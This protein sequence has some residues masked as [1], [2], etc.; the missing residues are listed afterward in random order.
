MIDL[1]KIED[2]LFK[3]A[4]EYSKQSR[5]YLSNRHSFHSGSL[6]EKEKKMYE[7]KLGEKI[8]KQYLIENN[9]EFMEDA[10][11]YTKADDYDFIINKRYLVDVKT[12]T[13]EYHTRT[14]EMVEQFNKKPKHIYISVRLNIE[15]LNG[16]ILGWFGKKDL[17]RINRVE[18]NGYLDNYVLYDKELREINTLKKY[19][20]IHSL[21]S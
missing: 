1:I 11:H 21:S 16:Y 9:I 5:E 2:K 17:M 4:Q 3:E 15:N 13:K 7:G 8:F 18:N 14:L 19:L 20:K 10:T 12:R 6:K